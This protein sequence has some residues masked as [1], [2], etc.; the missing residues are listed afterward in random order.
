MAVLI[1]GASVIYVPMASF[2]HSCH[3]CRESAVSCYRTISFSMHFILFLN[4]VLS[5]LFFLNSFFFLISTP[6]FTLNILFQF[7]FSLFSKF[8]ACSQPFPPEQRFHSAFSRIPPAL[9]LLTASISQ[10]TFTNLFLFLHP[11]SP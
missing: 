1:D 4:S 8:R 6:L 3:L 9:S 2:I 11:P 5:L 7:L 10:R